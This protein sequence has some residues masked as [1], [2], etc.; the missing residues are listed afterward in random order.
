MQ[1]SRRSLLSRFGLSATALAGVSLARPFEVFAQAIDK[2]PKPSMPS[3]LKITGVKCGY[4]RGGSRLFVKI[5]TNQGI[6]GCGEAVDAVGGTYHLVQSF[7][8]RLQ[9]QSP[10]NPHRLFEDI[11]RPSLRRRTIGNVRGGVDGHRDRTLGLGGQ[12]ARDSGVPVAGRQ[13]PGQ[14][15]RLH[16]HRSLSGALPGPEKFAEAALEAKQMGFTAVKFDLDQ[17]NDPARYDRYNWTASPGELQRM[18]D[19]MSAARKAVGANLDI[20]ADMHGRYDLPTA[21]AVAKAMEPL[22]LMWLEEP[23]PAENVEAYR[24]IAQETS[25][26]ICAGE[27][28]YLAHGFRRL[29]EI[30][31]ADII[32]PDLQ[33]GR[34]AGGR[35]AHR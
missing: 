5:H 14:N 2:A 35:T 20:C 19:Q 28:I 6:W 11:R 29:L 31:G 1:T 32:M 25:T 13:V 16:G 24:L 8:R 34:R 7:G 18:F 26:P 12:G 9:G 17:A 30:G 22:K 3:D 23:V 21:L 10:L 33:K 27:N 4:I 15:P